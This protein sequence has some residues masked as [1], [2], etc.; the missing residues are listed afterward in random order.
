M[1]KIFGNYYPRTDEFFDKLWKEA[2][3]V[4]DTNVLLDM[5]RYSESTRNDYL[6]LLDQLSDRLWLPHQVALEYSR[7]RPDVISEQV[8]MYSNAKKLLSSLRETA[9]KEIEKF[10][11]FRIHPVLSRE[12]FKSAFDTPLTELEKKIDTYMDAHPDF[13]QEDPILDTILKLFD[14]KVGKPYDVERLKEIYLEGKDRYE[15]EVPPG[16]E[17]ARG[18]HKKEGDAIYGDLVLWF[19]II[20]QTIATNASSVMF[21]SSDLKEDWWWSPKGRKLGC[22]PELCEEMATKAKSHFYMYTS[23]RFLHYA[24]ERIKV[25]VKKESIDE[26]RTLE[27]KDVTAPELMSLVS[28]GS[29]LNEILAEQERKEQLLS[30]LSTPAIQAVLE[31]AQRNQELL[32]RLMSRNP[33]VRLLRM[34]NAQSNRIAKLMEDIRKKE[35]EK[36]RILSSI[37]TSGL[38]S[39]ILFPTGKPPKTD[40]ES[41]DETLKDTSEGDEEEEGGD[42]GDGK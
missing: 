37:D 38:V 34:H 25:D 26:V 4:L 9:A 17:D 20:D 10:L 16:Y 22:R 31:E 23:E 35:E 29:I 1:R 24:S 15:K 14:G 3:I 11:K 33:S 39:D 41:A 42:A 18:P 7:K 28:A 5:Y 6:S 32:D 12:D 40:V 36:Q 19:Q 2:L 21:L 27:M 30:S 8:Q 13:F